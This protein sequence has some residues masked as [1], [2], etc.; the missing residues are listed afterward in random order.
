[1]PMSTRRAYRA[2]LAAPRRPR[3]A[4]GSPGPDQPD[5]FAAADGGG[6]P[7]SG[8]DGRDRPIAPARRGGRR[9][10]SGAGAELVHEGPPPGVGH[11]RWYQT[12]V[13]G[14]PLAVLVHPERGTV[15]TA[16]ELDPESGDLLADVQPYGPRAAPAPSAPGESGPVLRRLL[17]RLAGSDPPI[18]R[19]QVLTS[20]RPPNRTARVHL[21]AALPLTRAMVSDARAVDQ[22][23]GDGLAMLAGRAT[24]DL[25]LQLADCGLSIQS[26]V[27]I[28]GLTGLIR[29]RYDP[30]RGHR[31]GVAGSPWPT[32]I[33]ATHHRH[34]RTLS[35]SPALGAVGWYHATAWVKS[36]P[37]GTEGL[38]LTAPLRLPRLPRLPL[39]RT[40]A[41][42]LA[43]APGEEPTAAG[44]VT[45]S[46][47]TAAELQQA[48][49]DFKRALPADAPLQLEWTDREHH[50]AFTHTLP[51]ATGL[52]AAPPSAPVPHF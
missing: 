39:P 22:R 26:F 11:L 3:A 4:D 17:D 38:D 44:Y 31:D 21:V 32:E 15:T 25:C 40:A 12:L 50:L 46:A 2:L 36:W 37:G 43:L 6:L 20:T 19:L 16:V 47:R 52:A 30:G 1:M 5:R 41:L 7:H 48:R 8:P 27:D 10:G 42:V 13:L 9:S 34:L 35:S 45:V 28:R 29:S 24:L 18:V 14:R 33:D 49:E 23:P 51:L